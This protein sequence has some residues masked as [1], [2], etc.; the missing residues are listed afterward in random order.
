MDN[1]RARSQVFTAIELSAIAL[2]LSD[3]LLDKPSE[4]DWFQVADVIKDDWSVSVD[5]S[6]MVECETD[7]MVFI[8]EQMEFYSRDFI[9]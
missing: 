7:L 8:K 4:V 5:F 3:K 9:L 1:K 6:M 2:D